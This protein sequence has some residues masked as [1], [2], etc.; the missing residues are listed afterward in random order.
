M[1]WT[2]TLEVIDGIAMKRKPNTKTFKVRSDVAEMNGIAVKRKSFASIKK[3]EGNW[4]SG[5]KN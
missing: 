2:G 3:G 4:N 1:K 5:G